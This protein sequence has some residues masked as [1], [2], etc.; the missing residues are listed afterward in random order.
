MEDGIERSMSM[1]IQEA[2]QKKQ[3]GQK[4]PYKTPQWPPQAAF[5]WPPAVSV[6]QVH[7]VG[8]SLP[9]DR[10]ASSY[11]LTTDRSASSYPLRTDSSPPKNTNSGS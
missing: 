11:P 9:T 4:P 5:G 1:L 2:E 3:M 6:E 7:P 10:S 8:L